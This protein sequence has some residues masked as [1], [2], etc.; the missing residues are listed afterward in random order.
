M[1]RMLSRREDGIEELPL[2]VKYSMKGQCE[3]MLR[4]ME[5]F[6]ESVNSTDSHFQ[7]ALFHAA[8]KGHK[9]CLKE[10]LKKGADPN[11]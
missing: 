2:V 4:A 3:K 5:I 7:S 11:Q 10:L 9:K 6:G 1:E 8:L